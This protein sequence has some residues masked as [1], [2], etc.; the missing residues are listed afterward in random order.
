M[1]V[2]NASKAA[3]DFFTVVRK[4]EKRSAVVPYD[5]KD[6][7][8]DSVLLP[9][10]D[11]SPQPFISQWAVHVFKFQRKNVLVAMHHKTRYSMCFTNLKKGDFEGF[12]DEFYMRLLNNMFKQATTA[13]LI[14]DNGN[15]FSQLEDRYFDRHESALIIKRSN[16]S[17][18]GTLNSLK[19]SLDSILSDELDWPQDF[20][21]ASEIDSELNEIPRSTKEKQDLFMPQDE[22]FSDFIGK[23]TDVSA[24]Q[25]N[26]F[27]HQSHELTQLVDPAEQ[28]TQQRDLPSNVI[29]LADYHPGLKS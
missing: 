12:L 16:S 29:Q 23:Y 24:S 10:P 7:E 8:L 17:V 9:Q 25:L 6:P 18:I 27:L 4:G 28:E 22:F 1:I 11:G 5:N 3:C 21:D 2:F 20:D 15:N 13:K 14:D 19:L 26:Q